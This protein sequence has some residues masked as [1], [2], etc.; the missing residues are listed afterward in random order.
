[1][2]SADCQPVCALQ[3]GQSDPRSRYRAWLVDL[4]GTLYHQHLVRLAM[5]AELLFGHWR[6]IP[7]LQAFRV[8]QENMRQEAGRTFNCPYHGQVERVAEQFGT[9]AEHVRSTVQYW[10]VQ[11]P[12]KWLRLFRRRQLIAEIGSFHRRGGRTAVV[13]DYPAA[14]KLTALGADSI[15]DVVVANGEVQGA[16]RLKPWPDGFLLAAS[17]LGV[18]PEECLVLGDRDDTD[19][20]AARRAKMSFELVT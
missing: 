3:P 14:K 12:L 18:S 20:E 7:L 10:M 11:R 8:A 6:V 1:M 9:T 19:G 17:Q 4:D 15:F 13:S 16:Y 5:G 2:I